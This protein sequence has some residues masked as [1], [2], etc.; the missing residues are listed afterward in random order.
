[1]RIRES[2]VTFQTVDVDRQSELAD[3]YKVESLPTIVAL[4]DGREVG[5]LI[6]F[7]NTAKLKSFVKKHR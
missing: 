7:Q 3:R 4:K 2:G 5:R 1:M 6:G